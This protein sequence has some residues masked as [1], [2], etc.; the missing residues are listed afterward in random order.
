MLRVLALAL[1]LSGQPE[2]TEHCATGV[3][4]CGADDEAAKIESNKV[5]DKPLS[6]LL[7]LV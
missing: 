6:T 7:L 1:A 5:T 4:G 3:E 2:D